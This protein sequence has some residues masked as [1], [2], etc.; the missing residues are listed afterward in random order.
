M[1]MQSGVQGGGEVERRARRLA[2]GNPVAAPSSNPSCHE[3]HRLAVAWPPHSPR[4]SLQPARP[5]SREQASVDDLIR[6]EA[7]VSCAI[8]G[9]HKLQLLA[10]H[11]VH[12][13]SVAF[14]GDRVV[15]CLPSNAAVAAAQAGGR[16]AGTFQTG[17]GTAAR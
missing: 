11:A 3:P 1:G 12:L 4:T 15:D 8:D 2:D 14:Q 17:R 6:T 5:H 9:P 13:Q 16:Q 10:I 7:A